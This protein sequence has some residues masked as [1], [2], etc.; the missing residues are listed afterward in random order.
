MTFQLYL[1]SLGAKWYVI[2]ENAERRTAIRSV[3]SKV[4]Y[5]T[6]HLMA[7]VSWAM[8]QYDNWST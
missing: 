5:F 3:L 1:T 2:A 6:S 8:F 7:L 4:A